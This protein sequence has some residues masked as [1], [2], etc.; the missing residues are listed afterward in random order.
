MKRH[1]NIRCI[2]IAA[3]LLLA[4]NATQGAPTAEQKKPAKKQNGLPAERKSPK[5]EPDAQRLKLWYDR[6]AAFFEEALPIGNGKLGAMIYGGA[7]EDVIQLNDITL[8][9]GQPVNRHDDADA[10]RWIPQIREALFR[11]DYRAADSL[12]LRVQGNNSQ[13]FLPLAEIRIKDLN[14]GTADDY[15]RELCLDDALVSDYYVRNHDSFSR[16]YFASAPDKVVA[17]RLRALVGKSINCRI[18][19]ASPLPHQTRAFDGKQ[20]TMTGHATGDPQHSVH[21]CSMLLARTDGAPAEAHDSVIE[22]RNV[23]EVVLYFVNETSFNGFDKHP[24][25]EGAPYLENAADDAWALLNYSFDE[26]LER[27]KT[28]YQQYF[29]RVQFHLDGAETDNSRTTEQQLRDY[30]DRR[31]GNPYLEMLYFQFGRYLLIASSRTKGVPANLQGLWNPHLKAPWRSNYTMN[32][33]LEENYWHAETA[34]LAEM[35]EPLIAF[36]GCLAENGKHTAR[37]YYGIHRGWC[38]SHNS[39]LWAM[40][41]PV[42]EKR[43]LPEWANWN[44]GGAWL[45]QAVWEHFLFNPDTTYL[46]QTAFP[47]MKGAAGFCADWLVENPNAPDE[48]ITAPSTSPENEYVTDS[49]YHGMTCYGGTADLAIIREL[50]HNTIVAARI[51]GDSIAGELRDK[52]S[53]LQPYR[54]GRRGNLQEWYYDWDDYD[55]T[56]RHQSH[57][58]GLY[59]GH[60]ITPEATPDLARACAKTLEIKGDKTTGWSTGWRISLQARLHAAENAYKTFQTLLTYVSPDGYRGADRRSSGGTYPNLMDAHPPFQIDG[61]FG[62]TAGVCEMLIQSTAADTGSDIHL[63]PALPQAWGSGSVKGLCARGGYV[64]DMTWQDMQITSFEIRSKCGGTV[65][66]HYNGISVTHNMTRGERFCHTLAAGSPK[67]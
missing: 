46:R 33:N 62:G 67:M 26:L 61:N 58:I 2:A 39:D 38:A 35:A 66:V 27:H 41:N 15:Y 17:V 63:L 25:A 43:E 24:V 21:F 50:F 28:D 7:D 12:Q 11:E 3:F 57:L 1:I 36:V 29:D 19:L 56:H 13:W 52:L 42:G 55:W 30:I 37:N 48:L 8:W 18:S 16:E 60:H 10:H 20:L 22:V 59:P 34:N 47:L 51:V 64:V 32:I 40:T 31:G 65:T 45:T 54:I 14:E 5:K 44:L 49:R 23:Q 9:T 4:G 53:R 6:S